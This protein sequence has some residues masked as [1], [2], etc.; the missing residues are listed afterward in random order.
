MELFTIDTILPA[1]SGILF[2][3]QAI[4]HLG[5]Y[6][7]LYIHNKETVYTTDVN[8]ENPPLS[9]IIVAKDAADELQE[10]LP[11]ILEQDYP[12]F[13]VIVIYDRSADDCDDTLKLLEDKYPN[14]YHT[15]IPDSAC[16]IIPPT[17]PAISAIKN[18][19]LQWASK[20]AVMNGW[21]LP[22]PIAARK[23]ING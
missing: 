4:Y 22:N 23:V 2:I 15:F 21:C 17:A 18:W 14:L 16:Y 19:A 9:V 3:T 5:L 12:E 6:N 11:F 20:P 1:A 10:N 8:A 7:K 13:E